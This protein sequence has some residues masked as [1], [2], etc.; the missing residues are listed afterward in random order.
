[1]LHRLQSI[2]LI[3]N[4]KTLI[5]TSLSVVST[6]ICRYLDFTANF[7]L[8]LVITAVVFPIVFSIS[9]A[10][11]RRETALD[12][13]GSLKAHGQALYMAARDWPN[14]PDEDTLCR[15]RLL[16][17]DLLIACRDL[18]VSEVEHL[19]KKEMQ[20]YRQ[21]SLLSGF[22]K[23]DLRGRGLA[24]GDVSLCNQ[25][26]SDMMVAF[27]SVKHIYQYRTPITLRTFSSI[28]ITALPTLY[29]PYFAFLAQGYSAGVAL[30]MPLLF[31]VTLVSLDNIQEHLENPFDQIGE[32]DITINAEAFLERLDA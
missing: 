9:A 17:G 12:R 32:D 11:T 3:I 27:E 21:F 5:V 6:Y 2:S 18:F 28:F 24:P 31:S 30:V 22:I 15:A 8:T 29:G 13:Y 14:A 25:H 16:L 7:P 10:Y 4:R 1:M 19:R 26:L 20:V 23:H